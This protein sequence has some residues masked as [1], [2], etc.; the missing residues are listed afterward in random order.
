MDGG[1]TWSKPTIVADHGVMPALIRTDDGILVCSY[2]R[3][4][5]AVICSPDGEGREWTDRTQIFDRG[6]TGYTDMAK[7]GP[8][9][10]LLIHDGIYGYTELGDNKPHNYVFVVPLIIERAR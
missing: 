7:T 8:N 5:V 10:I 1:K 2:G 4:G 6:T 3:P 9:E